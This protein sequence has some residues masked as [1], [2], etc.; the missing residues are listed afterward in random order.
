MFE[1]LE[2]ELLRCSDAGEVAPFWWRDDD[3]QSA[4]TALDDVLEISARCRAPLSLAVVP[5]GLE[6]SLPERLTGLEHVQVLQHGFDHRNY[7]PADVRKM[8]LG[9][10]RP[11]EQITQQISIGF[12][13]LRALFGEQFVPVM[14]PPWNRIDERV[15][16]QLQEIGFTGLSTLGP[17]NGLEQEAELKLVNVHVDIINW[18]QG[19]CF[20]GVSACEAQIV[21]HLSA[22]REG[23]VDANEPTGIMSH[24]LVHDD[25]CRQFLA[26][27]FEYLGTHEDAILLD[28]K[29]VFA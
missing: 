2:E 20:A 26:D 28:A 13:R 16:A 7:A 10:H 27:L 18:T 12:E 11:G 29:T 17:R 22:K 5:D 19:R 25:G 6:V 4:S 21:A 14:V 15:I 9:W 3:A 1:L 8:E 24:H 23:C